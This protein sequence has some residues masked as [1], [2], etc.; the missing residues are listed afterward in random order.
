MRERSW[1]ALHGELKEIPS[2]V[3]GLGRAEVWVRSGVGSRVSRL[4]LVG[5]SGQGLTGTQGTHP[6]EVHA[7][8]TPADVVVGKPLDMSCGELPLPPRRE[9][10][11]PTFKPQRYAQA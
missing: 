5:K 3:F 10:R 6:T 9:D 11:H 2:E 7:R 4:I 8:E 1:R